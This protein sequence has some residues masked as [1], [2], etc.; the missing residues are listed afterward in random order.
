MEK[1]LPTSFNEMLSGLLVFSSILLGFLSVFP[2][3]RLHSIKLL[4]IFFTVSLSFYSNHW[5]TYF[6]SLFII[7]TAIT[8]I[9]FLQNLAAIIRGNKD[10]FNY[11]I[12]TLS[13]EEKEKKIAKEQSQII[14]SPVN[15]KT[16]ESR[17]LM[18]SSKPLISKIINIEEKALDLLESQIGV[19]IQRNVRIRVGNKSMELD[20][21][22]PSVVDDMISERII[23]VKYIKDTNNNQR[24][25]NFILKLEYLTH[26]YSIITK[27]FTKPHLVIVVDDENG[28]ENQA[29]KKIK[30]MI[31]TTSPSMGYSIF[32]TS[33]L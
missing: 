2:K 20:G 21:L 26:E 10:Y 25:L 22:I 24:I 3:L 27:K 15:N 30:T 11:K 18:K 23:E 7:A 8:E 16:K 6:A 14:D 12:E 9:E 4:A 19:K 31:E 33:N 1:L 17:I 29:L 13:K 32:T 5:S 28:I